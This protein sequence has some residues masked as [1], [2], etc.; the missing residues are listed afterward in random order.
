M[1]S[2]LDPPPAR[3][4]RPLFALC[5]AGV[6]AGAVPAVV[7]PVLPD[8]SEQLGVSA[9]TANW[10]VTAGLLTSAITVPVLG[11]IADL[12]GGRGVLLWCLSVLTAGAVLSALAPSVWLFLLGRALQGTA[13]AVFPLAVTVLHQETTGHRRTSAVALVSG[14]LAVGGGTGPVAAG[15]LNSARPGYQTLFWCCAAVSALAVLL[16]AFLVPRREAFGGGRVDIAGAA[17]LGA[18]LLLVLL[19]LSLG[20]SAGWTSPLVV[21]AF[22]AAAAVLGAFVR[23]E[24]RH[25]DPLLDMELVRRRPIMVANL[26]SALVGAVMIVA[27]LGLTHLVRGEPGEAGYGFGA[28]ALTTAVVYLL[29]ST[30]A[31]MIAAPVG[32]RL[33]IR[34]GSRFTLVA[35]ALAGTGGFTALTFAHDRPYQVAVAGIALGVMVSLGYAALP[36]VLAGAVPAA[37]TGTANSAN[38]LARWIGGAVA[39]S[40]VAV[41]LAAFTTGDGPPHENAVVVLFGAGALAAVAV[42][43]LARFG[44]SAPAAGTDAGGAGTDA[45]VA[46]TDAAVAG[47]DVTDA[48]SRLSADRR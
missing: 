29:P 7:I 11:R 32:G 10:A 46:G 4:G 34:F 39:G 37:R 38:A 36:A 25:P 12:R 33:V 44:L 41:V 19:P 48:E 24:R 31:S 30:V 28:S 26:L 27:T 47:T 1:P 17:L 14:T 20:A 16:V 5:F 15:L 23:V 8:I 43:L 13:G 40:L 42:G 45:A 35:A 9:G 2:H 18:G 21:G 22:A 6:V 3:A